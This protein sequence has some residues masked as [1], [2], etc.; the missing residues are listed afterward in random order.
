M[1]NL[2]KMCEQLIDMLNK[3][4]LKISTAESFTAGRIASSIISVSGASAVFHE[5]IVAYSNEAKQAR[6]GVNISTLKEYGAVSAECCEEMAFSLLKSGA[7]VG[8]SSTGIAGPKS[9]N[10]L[11]PVGLCYIGI[12]TKDCS[13]IYEYNFKGNREE[14][15]NNA[16][17]E[18][19][20][21][22]INVLEDQK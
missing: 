15:T 17:N 3:R 14:I 13:V 19:I 21:N 6:L 9:D 5:G 10:T 12:A 16:V 18:A 11:K 2:Y 4:G 1:D 8:I 7:D 20:T 22:T